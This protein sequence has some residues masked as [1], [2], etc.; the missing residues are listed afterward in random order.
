MSTANTKHRL[1][2]WFRQWRIPL[3]NFLSRRGAIPSSDL[4]DVAQEV[5][6]RLLRY[7]RAELVEQPQAYLFKM[8]SNVAAEW[9][10]RARHR[11]P[12]DP[13]WLS[14]LPAAGSP[15]DDFAREAAQAEIE[16]AINTLSPRQRS[17][18]KLQFSEG[19]AQTEI[20]ARLGS[21]QRI[22]KRDLAKSYEK[23]RTTLSPELLGMVAHGRE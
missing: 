9:V 8:A 13:S 16:R 20:A 3:R 22:V 2:D 17:V 21:T 14:E 18:L 1:S 6:L 23:L 11:Y 15:H 12:H 7:D 19:L 4:D 5:F 10:M